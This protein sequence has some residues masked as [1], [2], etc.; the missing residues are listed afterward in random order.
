MT[1]RQQRRLQQK[2]ARKAEKK[3]QRTPPAAHTEPEAL[4]TLNNEPHA[5]ATPRIS[6]AKLL[7]NR[8][9][10][11]LSMGAVTPEG[12]AVVSQNATKHGLTGKFKVLP[13]ESQS[14]FDRLL[15]GLLRSESP[16][17]EDE[18]EMV[19]Q[20][21]EALWLSRRAVRLQNDC[22]AALESGTPEEQ[23]P[24]HKSLALYLRYQTAHDRTFFRFSAELRKRH[25]ERAR[26][27]RGFVSQQYKEAAERRRQELHEARQALQKTKQ[28]GQEIRNRLAAAKCV[29][30]ELRN[31]AAKSGSEVASNSEMCVAAA[32]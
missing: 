28:Q 13:S 9:N 24:A 32:A 14:D 29:A 20:M 11:Q 18:V 5:P 10:A 6:E 23:R 4:A 26:A 1:A 17:G 16:V 7:A 12:K 25:N 27:Q 30:L 8:A 2:L 15:A 31:R 3:A 19:H 22:F 21:A